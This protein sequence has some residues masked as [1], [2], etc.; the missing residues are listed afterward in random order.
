MGQPTRERLVS[1]DWS[2][3]LVRPCRPPSVSSYLVMWVEMK[4]Y[5]ASSLQMLLWQMNQ[6]PE[7]LLMSLGTSL[8]EKRKLNLMKCWYLLNLKWSC[9]KRSLLQFKID[10]VSAFEGTKRSLENQSNS[11]HIWLC[12]WRVRRL[13]NKYI[14]DTK[15]NISACFTLKIKSLAADCFFYLAGSWKQEKEKMRAHTWRVA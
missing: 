10:G 9:A 12:H 13:Q 4:S 5:Q 8:D 7:A 3:E 14:S 6:L 2:K 11:A 1:I 15:F